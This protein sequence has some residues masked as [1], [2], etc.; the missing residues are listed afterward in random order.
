MVQI[1]HAESTRRSV[2]EDELAGG[3]VGVQPS[4]PGGGEAPRVPSSPASTIA[5]GHRLGE[6]RLVEDLADRLGEVASDHDRESGT[7]SRRGRRATAGHRPRSRR[8]GCH[9]P[10]LRA[11]PGRSSRFG[12]GRRRRRPI[13]ST[14][15]G[16]GAAA[17]ARTGPGRAGR[18]RRRGDG[19]V[20]PRRRRR[21]HWRRRRS[22][23]A[24]RDG[25]ARGAPGSRRR[26]P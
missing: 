24:R 20:R 15:T 12:S 21:S 7:R 4:Q 10:P 23:A 6:Q 25:R 18:V 8:P 5:F 9:R 1:G 22:A 14:S 19:L 2:S 26:D 13:G 16:C 11:R 17:A 3:E